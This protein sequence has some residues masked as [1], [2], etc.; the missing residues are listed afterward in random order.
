[1]TTRVWARRTRF[2]ARRLYE[3]PKDLMA[4]CIEYFDFIEENPLVEEKCGF[5]E[6]VAVYG[7]TKKMRAM[8]PGGLATFLGV[9]LETLKKWKKNEA[10]LKP[11]LEWAE[12]IIYEQK[13]TGAAA[14]LL[15][16]V[17][18]SRDLGLSDKVEHEV[19]VPRM[20]IKPPD[21][22]TMLEPP[23]YM[24]EKEE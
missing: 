19:A 21:N 2:S 9:T 10:D 14:G 8:T 6:G 5:H 16:S 7:E 17:I 24:G 13:F 22:M 11:V 3:N 4:A 23:I 15:N 1:M 20:I 18:I 12:Q